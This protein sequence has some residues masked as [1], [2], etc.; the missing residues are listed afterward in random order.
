[1][2]CPNMIVVEREIAGYKFCGSGFGETAHEDRVGTIA[3]TGPG[4]DFLE[5][6]R[7]ATPRRTDKPKFIWGYS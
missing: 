7:L 2:Q 3:P 4:D 6:K 5:G 1:M